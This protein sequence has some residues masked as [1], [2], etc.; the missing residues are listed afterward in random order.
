ME[1]C[2]ILRN[3]LKSYRIRGIHMESYATL[4]NLM[5][6]YE[7]LWR[8]GHQAANRS[9]DAHRLRTRYARGTHEVRTQYARWNWWSSCIIE[10]DGI[11][12]NCMRSDRILWN[13]VKR[14]AILWSPMNYLG[15][16]WSPRESCGTLGSWGIVWDHMESFGILWNLQ[17]LMK[18]SR[19][20]W[21][22]MTAPGILCN[23]T[24]ANAML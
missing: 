15:S 2:V 9:G 14:H 1:S 21:G 8:F 18:S 6:S 5:K 16:P 10:L 13:S 12:C 19:N 4:W 11:P 24:R 3:L 23:P 17:D 7:T 20:P 22:I